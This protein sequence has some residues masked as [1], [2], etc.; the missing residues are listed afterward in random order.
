[1]ASC[2]SIR[3]HIPTATCRRDRPLRLM[4][5]RG[6]RLL[7]MSGSYGFDGDKDAADIPVRAALILPLW[8]LPLAWFR[9]DRSF[10]LAPNSSPLGQRGADASG[11]RTTLCTN[12]SLLSTGVGRTK[13]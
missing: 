13:G 6:R 12:R 9:P 7:D 2:S 8:A 5:V 1:M 4:V 10:L 11:P 3:F